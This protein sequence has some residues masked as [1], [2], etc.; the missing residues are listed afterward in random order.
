MKTLSRMLPTA[1]TAVFGLTLMVSTANAGCGDLTTL[2]APFQF[3][4]A[5]WDQAP[6][7]EASGQEGALQAHWNGSSDPSIVGLWQIQLVSKGNTTHNPAIPDGALIDFGYRQMH[8]DQTELLNSGGHAPAT[9]NFCMG[10]WGQSG[11]NAYLINHFALSYDATTG[12]LTNTVNIRENLTLSP[13]G[14]SYTGTFTIDVYDTK[15][16]HVDHLGGTANGTR[17]TVDSTVP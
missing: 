12:T 13:S 14:D 4:K 6:S 16:N 10:V 7:G 5:G 3:A 2:Q 8:S 11:F 9:E 17:L 1:L 15:G